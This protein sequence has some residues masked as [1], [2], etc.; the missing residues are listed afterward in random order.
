MAYE[1]LTVAPI[2]R[3]FEALKREFAHK[4]AVA[5]LKPVANRITEL[6]NIAIAKKQPKPTPMSCIRKVTD[7]GFRL[8]NFNM[9]HGY[10]DDCFSYDWFPNPV[11]IID[12]LFP[13]GKNVDLSAALPEIY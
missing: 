3:Q 12:K 10:L 6:W 2:R 4:I 7:A 11:E 13:P 8:H 1:G 5:H 9:L